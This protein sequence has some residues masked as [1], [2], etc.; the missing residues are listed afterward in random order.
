MAKR[1]PL[2]KNESKSNNWLLSNKSVDTFR[3][4]FNDRSSSFKYAYNNSVFWTSKK[5]KKTPKKFFG[6]F[7]NFDK[8]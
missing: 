3:G 5:A 2:N 4:G 1:L 6:K 7:N 8:R